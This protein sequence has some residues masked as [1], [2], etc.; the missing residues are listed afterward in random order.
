MQHYKHTIIVCSR[1]CITWLSHDT[2]SYILTNP[3]D[4]MH[5]R[6]VINHTCN[7]CVQWCGNSQSCRTFSNNLV[8]VWYI[9][10]ERYTKY[11][12][13]RTKV[14]KISQNVRQLAHYFHT[15]V[16]VHKTWTEY[17]LHV[18]SNSCIYIT[19]WSHVIYFQQKDEVYLNLLLDY[20]PDT[21]YRVIRHHYK[22]KQIMPMLFI[23]V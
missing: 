9:E 1:T 20:I 10:T 15:P 16:C 21:V 11:M 22:A 13:S 14:V 17:H 4:F 8:N 6:I 7:S 23:K 2:W 18:P 19:W 3:L 5:S 12:E